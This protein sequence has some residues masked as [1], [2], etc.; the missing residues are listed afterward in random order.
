MVATGVLAAFKAV[1][2]SRVA[3]LLTFTQFFTWQDVWVASAWLLFT[4]LFVS[5]VASVLTLRKYLKV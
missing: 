3:P 5:T 4:G 1:V 2:D